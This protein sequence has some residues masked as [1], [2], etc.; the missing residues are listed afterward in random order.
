MPVGRG[1]ADP[2]FGTEGEHHHSGY[3]HQQLFVTLPNVTYVCTGQPSGLVPLYGD[4]LREPPMNL[5]KLAPKRLWQQRL[6][7]RRREFFTVEMALAA[8]TLLLIAAFHGIASEDRLLLNLYYIGIA[9]AAYALVKRRALAL[10]VLIVFVAAGTTLAQ[11]YFAAKSTRGDPLLDPLIDLASLCVLLFLGWRLGV[12]AY[13]FQSEEH[14]LQVQREIDEKAMATRAAAL[15]STSHEVRQPLSAILAITETLLDES[16]GPMNE[17]QRDFVADVD[18]C[19]KHLMALI[20]DILDYAKAEAGMIKLSPETVA[21]PALV[22]QCISMAEPRAAEAGVTITAHVD[23]TVMEIVADP[24]RLKQVLLNLLSN[25]VKFNEQG[26]FVKMQVRADN[27]D[28]VISVRDTGRGID[29]E[30]IGRLFDPYYQAA[31]G[32]Q[33]IGTGLGLSIIKH[34]VELH[35]GSISVDSVP[36]SGS[37]FNVRLPGEGAPATEAQTPWM[38]EAIEGD[39]AGAIGARIDDHQELAV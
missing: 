30:K 9:G 28:V 17:V 18:E 19:A 2:A 6:W 32:D 21:L 5:E 3:D 36:G 39:M 23:P 10:T 13:R 27:K 1:G 25:A 22:D 20:N 11:V 8:L 14:R 38:P 33:G 34:L 26:G 15:T 7:Q 4:D 31:H 37:V 16:A 24:L 12:E 35:G 29:P